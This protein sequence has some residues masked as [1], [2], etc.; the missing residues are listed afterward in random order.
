MF[1]TAIDLKL[2]VD[3]AAE[4]VVR[5]HPLDS[6]LDEQ[7]RATLAALTE[8]LGLV[9]AHETG[10]AHVGFLSLFLAADL[11][12]GSID[13]N[14]KVTGVAVGGENRLVLAAQEICGFDGDVAEMLV[15]CINDPPLAFHFVCFGGKCLH[16]EFGKGWKR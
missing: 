2:A 10:K 6:A 13:H 7:L 5:N 16:T 11:D 3:R 4:T 12:V 8:C 9:S 15:L 1:V 14:D